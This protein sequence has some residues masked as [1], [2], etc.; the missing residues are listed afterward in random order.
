[1]EKI[2]KEHQQNKVEVNVEEIHK[3]GMEKIIDSSL[4]FFKG[5][6]NQTLSAK[7]EEASNS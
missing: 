4:G 6:V 1:M 5:E 3:K 2:R 7:L